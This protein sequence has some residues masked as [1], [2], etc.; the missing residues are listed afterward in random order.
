MKEF[1][2]IWEGLC[3]LSESKKMDR[4]KVVLPEVIFHQAR[5]RALSYLYQNGTG[6]DPNSPPDRFQFLGITYIKE[7]NSLYP[8]IKVTTEKLGCFAADSWLMKEF[9]K[10]DKKPSILK[11]A[12]ENGYFEGRGKGESVKFPRLNTLI[13][14]KEIGKFRKILDEVSYKDWNFIV[15]RDV[16]SSRCYLQIQFKGHCSV[17]GEPAPQRGRKWFLSPH[18]TK[19]E[20][21][22]T[23]FK[24]VMTAEEHETREHFKYKDQ[25]I[26][27]PHFDVDF[28]V[29]GARYGH[30][31][32]REKK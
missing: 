13:Q 29:L 3:I 19:S 20:V 30:T 17:T 8:D 4:I 14:D 11:T 10:M 6:E 2:N 32:V 9:E 1:I 25:A 18:M 7:S 16:G 27:G 26:Y 31:D 5:A 22:S 12:L 23:A 21:V 28:L 24:A 15:D